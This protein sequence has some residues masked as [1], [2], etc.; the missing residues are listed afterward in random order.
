MWGRR[1]ADRVLQL[2]PPKPRSAGVLEWSGARVQRRDR[3]GGAIHEYASVFL[4]LHVGLVG[5]LL[6]QP[7]AERGARLLCE[8]G[9]RRDC[10]PRIAVTEIFAAETA[11][12]AEQH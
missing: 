10:P 8:F 3:L 6:L 4:H 9:T 5:V 2:T 12:L 1:R 7:T 11:E